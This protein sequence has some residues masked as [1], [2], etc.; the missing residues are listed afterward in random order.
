MG[1]GEKRKTFFHEK[2]PN[3]GTE[4]FLLS[5]NPSPLFKKSGVFCKVKSTPLVE[6]IYPYGEQSLFF[7]TYSIGKV[8]K[9]RGI[10]AF[11][12]KGTCGLLA[13]ERRIR[14]AAAGMEKSCFS[15]GTSVPGQIAVPA[16]PDLSRKA[17]KQS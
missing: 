7:L 3:V 17:G 4:V 15:V 12:G 10:A 16:V 5:P 2:K 11:T 8:L 9:P 13:A 1:T 6:I 14:G